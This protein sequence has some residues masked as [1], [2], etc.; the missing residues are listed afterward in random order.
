[1]MCG[2]ENQGNFKICED[3]T[4]GAIDDDFVHH[5]MKFYYVP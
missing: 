4:T 5:L 2:K 3:T 1:M